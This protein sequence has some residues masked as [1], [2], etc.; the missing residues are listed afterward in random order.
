METDGKNN[1]RAIM[2][3]D[4]LAD[5][6]CIN[7]IRMKI[8]GS[9]GNYYYKI[10]HPERF[11]FLGMLMTNSWNYSM[12]M[13]MCLFTLLLMKGSGILLLRQ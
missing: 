3:F 1:L 6:D 12:Q 9:N 7:D 2:A 8:T 5:Y 13:L 11:D 10:K 4:R